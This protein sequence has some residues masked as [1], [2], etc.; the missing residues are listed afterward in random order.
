M[1][2]AD[3]GVAIKDYKMTPREESNIKM[4]PPPEPVR[5]FFGFHLDLSL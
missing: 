5:R 4:L 3:Q 1:L 2:Q